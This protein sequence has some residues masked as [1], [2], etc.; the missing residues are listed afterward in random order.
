MNENITKQ[1]TTKIQVSLKI[2]NP[3]KKRFLILGREYSILVKEYWIS[4]RYFPEQILIK[5]Y[6]YS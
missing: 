3:K 4:Q 2:K 5:I 1:N 6:A